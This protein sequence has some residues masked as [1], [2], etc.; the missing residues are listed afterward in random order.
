MP[1]FVITEVKL[2]GWIIFTANGGKYPDITEEFSATPVQE[3]KQGI[4]FCA[5]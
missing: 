4:L 2:R 5:L 3:N 1:G